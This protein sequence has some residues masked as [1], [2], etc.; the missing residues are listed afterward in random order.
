MLPVPDLD[1]QTFEQLMEEAKKLI[2]QFAPQWTDFNLHDPGV[3]FLELLVWLTEMQRYY[4]NRIRD[5]NYHKFLKL[6][7]AR[8]K[9]AAPAKTSVTFSHPGDVQGHINVPRGSRLTDGEVI[10]ETEQTLAVLEI[11]INK[12]ISSTSSGYTDSTHINGREGLSYFAFGDMAEAGS[13]LYL[14]FSNHFY[15]CKNIV[16]TFKLFEDYPVAA[17]SYADNEPEII[18]CAASHARNTY[19]EY[20]RSE[21]KII[22]NIANKVVSWAP[23]PV[24]LD[25]TLDFSTSGRIILETP[26][27]MESL[28]LNQS[29][30]NQAHFWVRCTVTGDGFELAPKIN[31]IV[32]NTVPV[33]QRETL[34]E[35]IA[36]SSDGQSKIV[37][38]GV[39]YLALKG[40]NL[41]QAADGAGV[42]KDCR[43]NDYLLVKDEISLKISIEFLQAAPPAGTALRLLAWLPEFAAIRLPGRSDG[44]PGQKFMLYHPPVMLQNLTVQVGEDTGA[45]FRWFDW[46]RV[47][48]FDASGPADRHYMFNAG[49]GEIIFGDGLNGLIPPVPQQEEASNI[50]VI[51]C[52]LGGG[53]Q[54]NVG[55]GMINDIVQPVGAV[56]LLKAENRGAARGGTGLETLEKAMLNARKSLKLIDRAVTNEDFERLACATPGLRVARAKAYTVAATVNIVVVPLSNKPKPVPGRSFLA[57]VCRH[58]HGHRLLTTQLQVIAPEY[59]KV[60][61]AAAVVF[62]SGFKPDSE[63]VIKRLELYICPLDTGEGGRGWPFGRAVYKSEVYEVI[64]KLEGVD[65]VENLQLLAEGLRVVVDEYGNITLPPNG[66]VYSGEHQVKAVGPKQKCASQES[67]GE[68]YG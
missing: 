26:S 22:D 29:N 23:L 46:L 3:T 32:L 54:G 41:I 28:V 35:F 5:E 61:V 42:W 43:T 27:D 4:L 30:D 37:L 12:I 47:A 19:W 62:K 40:E 20:G 7:D 44:L 57:G 58:L 25:E 48:D 67:Y 50:C 33:V 49:T 64:S 38:E 17:G 59:I 10:F 13:R 21:T 53:A 60:S 24:E 56:G 51:H 34:G 36:F 15:P 14:G 16:L 6:L 39:S 11:E 8:P 9:G 31:E 1:D 55:K 65:Y 18:L 52:L 66:L 63:K 2:P 45:G 68:N